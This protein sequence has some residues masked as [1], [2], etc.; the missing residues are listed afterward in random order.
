MNRAGNCIDNAVA[1]SFNGTAK[2]ELL[3]DQPIP[4][5]R[6]AARV[7][8]KNYIELFYNRERRHSTFGYLSPVE[9]ETLHQ[10]RAATMAA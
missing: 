8:V 2:T 10:Q 4:V 7:M 6:E 9:F 3:L 5:T 1:E